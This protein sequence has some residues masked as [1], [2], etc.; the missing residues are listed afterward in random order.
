MADQPPYLQPR[1]RHITS[2]RIHRLT[3]ALDEEHAI[4]GGQD[5][6]SFSFTDALGDGSTSGTHSSIEGYDLALPRKPI[7]KVTDPNHRT[8]A[9]EET[10]DATNGDIEASQDSVE[11]VIDQIVAEEDELYSGTKACSSPHALDPSRV[12]TPC[13]NQP[14]HI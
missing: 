14:Q 6:H 5:D 1:I 4:P 12:S 8:D 13:P 10:E 7:R 9:V 11:S 3:V 2:I